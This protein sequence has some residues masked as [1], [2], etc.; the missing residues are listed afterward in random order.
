MVFYHKASLGK[1]ILSIPKIMHPCPCGYYTD[2][3]SPYRCNPNKIFSYMS[4][5]SG[6]LLDGIDKL[7]G[8]RTAKNGGGRTRILSKEL[9]ESITSPICSRTGTWMGICKIREIISA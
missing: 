8:K 6:S 9:S 4:K 5:I 7:K 2:P 1:I 3:K